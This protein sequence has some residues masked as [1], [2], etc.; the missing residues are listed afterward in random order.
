MRLR[1]FCLAVAAGLATF[2]LAAADGPKPGDK[3]RATPDSHDFVFFGD[4]RPLL[5][6]LRVDVDAKP[7]GKAYDDFIDQLFKYLDTNKDGVLSKAEADRIPPPELLFNPNGL[8][9][10]RQGPPAAAAFGTNRTGKITREDLAEYVRKNGG[11]A[12]QLRY[13]GTNPNPNDQVIFFTPLGGQPAAPEDGNEALFKL[14]DTNKDGKLSRAELAAAPAVLAKLD[15]DEDE[16]IS[17][18][19]LVPNSNDPRLGG[20][21]VAPPRVPG[22]AQQQNNGPFLALAPGES[23]TKLARELLNRYGKGKKTLTRADLGLD[24]ETFEA[25]DADGDGELDSEELAHFGDRPADLEAAVHFGQRRANEL[26]V[27]MVPPAGGRT[28]RPG[29]AR[30]AGDGS[31]AV[32]MGNTRLALHLG[33]QTGQGDASFLRQQYIAQFKQA[34]RDNNGYLDENEARSSPFFRNT[35]K[36]MDRDGDGKL[37]ENEM[38]AYVDAMIEL[39]VKAM[40]AIVSLNIADE[41]KGIFDLIDTNHDGR[42]S[43]RELRQAANLVDQLDQDGDGAISKG[44]IPR[45]YDLTVQRGPGTTGF[46]PRRLVAATGGRVRGRPAVPQGTSGPLWFRKMDRNHDGDVSRREF[47]GTDE[48]FRRI[49]AD[50]DGLISAAEAERYDAQLRKE[51]GER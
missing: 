35:F 28:A 9:N 41:G 16:M 33:G 47:L 48:E 5:V 17:M 3:P 29:N 45:S 36:L 39:Q 24:K 51:K 2:C 11:P 32:D 15:Q 20:F 10:F 42:L 27:E 23:S 44:E 4:S 22:M 19:E 40:A 14:L 6:R 13:L 26:P 25:L 31:L 30:M 8:F 46:G 18:D 50:G 34:D 38:L 37:F 43:I 49:D 1:I 21:A 7:L 12:F